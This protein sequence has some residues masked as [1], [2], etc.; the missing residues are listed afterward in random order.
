MAYAIKATKIEVSIVI[1]LK[2]LRLSFDALSADGD[3][4]R[5]IVGH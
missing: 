4:F 1:S 3:L 2:S 5:A